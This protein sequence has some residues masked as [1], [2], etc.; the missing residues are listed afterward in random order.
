MSRRNQIAFALTLISFVVLY[1]GLTMPALTITLSSKAATSMG[2]ME[3]EVF[4]KTR[5]IVGTIRE[6]FATNRNL[7][8][9][10]ILLFSVIVPVGKG[11][12]LL[13]A[14]LY[15][16]RPVA[17]RLVG[18]VRRIGK[19]SMA[20]VMVVAVFLAYLSTN[21]QEDRIRETMKVM[22]MA[23]TV[24]LSSQMVSTLQ[25]GFYW[26]LAYCLISLTSMEILKVDS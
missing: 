4:N 24:D 13:V 23:V 20:D 8:G 9:C 22:G 3:G 12:I 5:S 6:L 14:L 10:L 1:F 26:F 17:P 15:R 16:S 18:F 19:W 2:T 7:V 25:A 11:V 21:Y